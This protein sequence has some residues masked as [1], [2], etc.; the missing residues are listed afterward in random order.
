M[1]PVD[2]PSAH[3]QAVIADLRRKLDAAKRQ[4]DELPKVIERLEEVAGVSAYHSPPMPT[5]ADVAV[6]APDIEHIEPMTTAAGDDPIH[7]LGLGDACVLVL[8]ELGKPA[9]NREILDVLQSRGFKINS[10]NPMNNVGTCLNHRM[11]NKADI[12]RTGKHWAL[13]S[14]KDMSAQSEM[15]GHQVIQ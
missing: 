10:D 7:T 9:S 8:G 6:A 2:E 5:Q 12:V 3:Y 14:R 15:N 11:K 13:V 1:R 4:V